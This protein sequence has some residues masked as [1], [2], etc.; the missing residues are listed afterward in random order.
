[1]PRTSRNRLSQT[2]STRNKLFQFPLT[3]AAAAALACSPLALTP[4]IMP[5]T[6]H[7]QANSGI[8]GGIVKDASGALIPNATIT[9]DN[10]V[11]G[12]TR[13]ATSDAQGQFRFS[14]V[15]F[16]PYSLTVVMPGFAGVSR[17]LQV[18]SSL[19]FNLAFNLKVAT[20]SSVVDVTAPPDLIEDDPTAHTDIDRST[21]DK[22]PVESQSSALS[23]IVTQ[24]SPGVAADS[25]GLL[26]GLGDHNEVSFSIDGQPIT[27]QQ[28][29]VF[30]NQVPADAIQSLEVIEGAPPAEYGDKTSL[31]IVAT[32]RSGLGVRK[33]TGQINAS[34]GNFGTSNLSVNVAKGNDTYGNF[35]SGNV[36]Q[37]GR[38]L[39]APEF[40]V[41]HDK[42]NEENLFDR[43][44]YNLSNVSSLH[45]N[46][47][48]TRSWFQTPNSYDT[49]FGFASQGLTSGPTDQR[50]KIETF[51]IAPSYTRTLGANAVFN[52]GPYVRKDGYNYNPSKNPLNDLGPIQQESVAQYRSLTNAGLHTD[53]T[54][55]RGHNTFKVGGMYEQTFLRESDQI[56]LV[57]PTLNDPTSANYNAILAP[58]DLTRGGSPY[59]YLGRTDVKQL[60]LYGEDNISAGA[61]QFNLGIRGDIYNGLSVQKVAEPRA[62]L[63]YT[64]K[65]TG[66]VL[67]AS[68]ARTQETPFNENLVLSSQGCLNPIIQ[69][70]FLTLG[71]CNPAP[72]NP[73][74][75]NEF[76]LG[77]EQAV[78][79][80][81][82]LSGEYITKYTHN[83][84]DFSVLGATPIAFPIEWHNSK[85]PGYTLSGTLT[86]THGLSARVNFSSVAARFFNPQIGGVGAT[87][88]APGGY[89]FRIDHDERFNQS[90]NIDYRMPFRKS[91]YYSFNWR[92]D[93]GL[94]AGSVPCYN[95]TDPNSACGGYSFDGNGNPLTLNGQPAIDLSSLTPDE[96][97]QA[98]LTCDGVKAT[99]T[100]G[101]SICDA[102]G[103]TSKLVTVPAPGK[104]DDDHDPQRVSPR[105]LF[106]MEL[107]DD[108]IAHFG[109]SGRDRYKVGARLTAINVTNKYA[110][111]NFL[112]TFS[113][114][115]YV[116]PR[117]VTAEVALHF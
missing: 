26:H 32:T 28:S 77:F 37:S 116:T 33:A 64:I 19:P 34:Y 114:T 105:N 86:Q 75:R 43:F 51:D 73:G 58:I 60:A 80:H 109:G 88:G 47:Q 55:T 17:T 36:L 93:S 25:D 70:V 66:T 42:G 56:G 69:A 76:H 101:F 85:I 27:D 111:Y 11:S 103:L 49:Q 67:R 71:T 94:V 40:Q 115:H 16:N 81:F 113:G 45:L 61:W 24:L 102:A 7:A 52:F 57:D 68:Y 59:T 8:V 29:K 3:R 83:A 35:F 82:V 78:G 4:F 18:N 54:Y 74:F 9:L 38:F 14:N 84:Y 12:Y 30:S 89:P 96:E 2:R 44:D 79:S 53:V 90:T 72:F 20:S 15:P 22:L 46:L 65:K 31:V 100:S 110:L 99:Q 117:T 63:S 97:F 10:P 21:I 39:D 50:S 106:D 98:G 92:F 107:G 87:V 1:M 62:G 23:S 108:S 91:M 5:S 13:T 6:L 95:T 48:Y 41:Y 112:S 104:E